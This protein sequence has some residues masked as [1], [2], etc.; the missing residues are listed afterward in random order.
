MT[1]KVNY[2]WSQT[3]DIILLSMFSEQLQ[4]KS[5]GYIKARLTSNPRADRNFKNWFVLISQDDSIQSCLQSLG[6]H[7]RFILPQIT[8]L[9]SGNEWDQKSSSGK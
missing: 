4:P 7:T 1:S 8:C 3:K 2:A 6:A 9:R 5:A